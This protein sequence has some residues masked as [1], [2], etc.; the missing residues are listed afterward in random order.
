[1][2]LK[3][4]KRERTWKDKDHIP[5]PRQDKAIRRSPGLPSGGSELLTNLT[6]RRPAPVF[7]PVRPNPDI[8]PRMAGLPSTWRDDDEDKNRSHQAYRRWW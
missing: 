8:G 2:A 7:D 5:R 6:I 4:I 3:N 1:M